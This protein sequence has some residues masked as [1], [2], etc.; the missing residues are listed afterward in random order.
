MR[1]PP[2]KKTLYWCDACGVPLLAKT[3]VCGGTGRAIPLPEPYDVRPALRH[4]REVLSALLRERFGDVPLPR[5]VL[6]SKAGGPDRTELVIARGERFG[7]LSFDPVAREFRFDI[8]AGGIPSVLPHATRGVVTLEDAVAP[9]SALPAGRLGGK[10]VR[11]RTDEPD[12]TV[13]VRYRGRAGTGVLREG[14]LRVRELLPLRGPPAPDPPWEEAVRRNAHHL[15]NLERHAV[16]AI[17]QH[18]RDRPHVNVSFSG[19]KDSTAVLALAR[20]AGVT[21]AFFIDTGLEFPETLAFVRQ[22][23]IRTVLRGGDFWS[24]AERDGPPT[25]DRRWC[26]DLLKQ[27]PLREYIARQGPTLTVQGNRWYESRNRAELALVRENPAIPLQCT[28]SP[29]RNWRALEVFMYLW[30]REIP[31]NPLYDLGF[32]RIGCYVCPAMLE[33]EAERLAEVHPDLSARWT[34]F[35]ERWA[36]SRGLPPAYVR[37]GLWR[38]ETLPP[39]MRELCRVHGIAGGRT[40]RAAPARQGG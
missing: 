2:V 39:K 33:A 16:R 31:Y 20:K 28:L 18:A 36:R 37:C 24:A 21:D 14:Y 3:C 17:R 15:R 1:E 8:A 40:P 7:W 26:C 29:I 35:L 13:I 4:D 30:W 23:G 25:K 5:I 12:G 19:G 9:G 11:V 27:A 10:R 34:R 6:L 22:Q 32:E 38:W